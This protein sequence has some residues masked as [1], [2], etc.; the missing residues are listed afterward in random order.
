MLKKYSTY[1][2]ILLFVYKRPFHTSKTLDYLEKNY[3]ANKS[4]LIIFSDA[5]KSAKDKQ[6]VQEVREIIQQPRNFNKIIIH[7]SK[8]NTGLAKSII[9]G[10]TNVLK[11]NKSVIVLEDDLLTHP[12]FLSYMNDGLKIYKNES[13]VFSVTGYNYPQEVFKIRSTQ[14]VYFNYRQCSWGWGTWKDRWETID[15]SEKMFSTFIRNKTFQKQ[16]NRAGNDLSFLLKQQH[17]RLIDSW[18]IRWNYSAFLQDKVAV[19]PKYSLIDNIGFDGSGEHSGVS[20][21]YQNDLNYKIKQKVTFP[22]KIK[23]DLAEMNK[24]KEIFKIDR[25]SLLKYY[26]YVIKTTIKNSL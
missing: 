20:K 26:Y 23:V 24:F 16:F 21:Q 6:A 15:W 5:A 22:E 2:P 10:V 25:V 18:A 1:A 3:L 7:K 17:A 19:Y 14:D 9:Q 11:Q 13:K 4:T 8:K 12:Y